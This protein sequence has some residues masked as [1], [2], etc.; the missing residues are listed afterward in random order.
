MRGNGQAA[1]DCVAELV[2]TDPEP[3]NIRGRALNI[4]GRAALLLGDTEVAIEHLEA[5]LPLY[6]A[7]ADNYAQAQLLQNIVTVYWRIGRLNDA[8]AALHEVVALQR[9]L[10]GAGPLALALTSLGYAYH[11]LGDYPH[12]VAVLQEGLSA[13]ARFP[14][15]R[16]EGYL[17]Y[18]LAD[19]RRDQGDLKAAL[20][21][22][23]RAIDIVGDSEP[24]LTC[25]ILCG[26]STLYR[27]QQKMPDA[28]AAA[29]EAVRLARK[30][31]I[32][33]EGRE[34]RLLLWT[35]R[36]H[37]GDPDRALDELEQ[38]AGEFEDRQE[39]FDLLLA[40]GLC[41]H[42]A[43]CRQS[44]RRLAISGSGRA[45]WQRAWNCRAARRRNS[46]SARA[47][48]LDAA[49]R[50]QIQHTPQHRRTASR[51][52]ASARRGA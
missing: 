14:N 19:V 30:Q 15:P 31:N 29:Q 42:A 46:P 24:S 48:S 51:L 32:G 22:Y 47:R 35:A 23:N 45:A 25:S 39:R 49:E 13:I 11:Q 7:Y 12:A 28:I 27:W 16:A 6:R 21:L 38:V 37:E 2:H 50:T 52:A 3:T 40:M 41:A 43:V 34:A 26:I 18:N 9:S 1:I 5:A 20:D 36:I 8:L 17:L 33:T 10:G 4:L 44:R